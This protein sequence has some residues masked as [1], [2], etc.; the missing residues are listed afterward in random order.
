LSVLPVVRYLEPLSLITLL[1]FAA[2][3]KCFIDRK[4]ELPSQLGQETFDSA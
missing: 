2:A 3:A 1:T 4:H